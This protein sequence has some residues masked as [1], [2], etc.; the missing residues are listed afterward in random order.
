MP[1]IWLHNLQTTCFLIVTLFIHTYIHKDIY[2][3]LSNLN[4]KHEHSLDGNG[5]V[6]SR[7]SKQVLGAI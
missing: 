2:M 4:L 5:T 6:M 1:E 7:P 3:K